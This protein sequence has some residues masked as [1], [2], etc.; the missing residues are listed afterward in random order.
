MSPTPLGTV[1]L[2]LMQV[3][4]ALQ[5]IENDLASGRA[6]HVGER[7]SNMR[8][9][10]LQKL[11]SGSPARSRQVKPPRGKSRREQEN[12]TVGRN[13]AIPRDSPLVRSGY[14]GERTA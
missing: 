9:R 8:K 10:P 7:R 5:R 12:Q 2:A 11:K 13:A 1:S 14:G 4:E 3:K 6:A